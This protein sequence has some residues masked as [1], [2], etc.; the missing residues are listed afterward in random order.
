VLVTLGLLGIAPFI[1]VMTTSFVRIVVVLSLVRSAIGASSLPPNAV[2]TG[3][4]LMLTF[5]IMSPTLER[6]SVDALDPYARGQI[7]QRTMLARAFEPLRAFM[8][9]QTHAKDLTLF[10][11]LAHERDVPSER[12]SP[13]VLLP[14]FVVGELRSAFAIGLALYLPFVAIDLA[15]A[16]ILMGLGMFMLSPP[17]VSLPCKL[18]LFV[19]V[20]GWALVCGGLVSTFR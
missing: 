3:L 16:S 19:M 12:A 13:A 15:V 9:R 7:S 6:V 17:I 14:A 8:L 5:V 20:D 10:A 2:L 11:R 1:L 4:A 18:L